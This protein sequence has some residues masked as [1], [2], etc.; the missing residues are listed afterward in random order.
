M[1]RVLHHFYVVVSAIVVALGSPV[2]AQDAAADQKVIPRSQSKDAAA[3]SHTAKAVRD[4]AEPDHIRGQVTRVEGSSITVKTSDGKTLRIGLKDDTTVISLVKGSFAEVDFGTY[5]GAVAVKLEAY[6]PIVRD[7][8]VWL[9]KGFELRIIDEQLRGIALGHR[10]WDLTPDSI[11]SHGW[12]DDIEVRVLSIK[13]GP[14]DYDE[15]DVEI[16]RDVPVSRMSIGDRSLIKT[17][18]RVF[19]GGKKG[20]DGQYVALFVFVGKDGVVPVL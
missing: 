5:V 10:K 11:I 20:S 18:A 12:V 2:R 4:P 1:S 16:P 8:A 13:W 9:H 17:G 3:E 14:T 19:I 6:S 15:T 7:S